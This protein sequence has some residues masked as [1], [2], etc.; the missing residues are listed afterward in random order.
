V[1]FALRFPDLMSLS[2]H[3][4]KMCKTTYDSINLS[5]WIHTKVAKI[6]IV[7]PRYPE[8]HPLIAS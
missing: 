3:H 8:K 7:R 5:S 4:I 2:A 6:S 1:Y